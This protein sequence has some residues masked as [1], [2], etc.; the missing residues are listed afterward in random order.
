M[1][2]TPPY[3]DGIVGELHPASL[4]RMLNIKFIRIILPLMMVVKGKLFHYGTIGMEQG[5]FFQ[6]NNITTTM[7]AYS[8]FSQSIGAA[9]NRA[10]ISLR[11][12]L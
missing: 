6:I 5:Q 4:N 7:G 9:P 12:P 11:T 2:D 3:S 1:T 10:V 8:D